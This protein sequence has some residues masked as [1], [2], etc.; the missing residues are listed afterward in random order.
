MLHERYGESDVVPPSP[1][2]HPIDDGGDCDEDDGTPPLP[3]TGAYNL[4]TKALEKDTLG[5]LGAWMCNNEN[6]VRPVIA[7]KAARLLHRLES[8]FSRA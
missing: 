2:I 5:R 3:R 8:V 1:T 4:F 6:A 7:G